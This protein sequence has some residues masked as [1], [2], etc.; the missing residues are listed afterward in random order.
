MNIQVIGMGGYGIANTI[1]FSAGGNVVR[2]VDFDS[3]LINSLNNKEMKIDDLELDRIYREREVIFCDKLEASDVYIITAPSLDYDEKVNFVLVCIERIKALLKK[4]DTIIL[5]TSLPPGT[6]MNVVKPILEQTGLVA[7]VDFYLANVPRKVEPYYSDLTLSHKIIGG[8]GTTSTKK[9]KEIYQFINKG[10]IDETDAKTAEVVKSMESTYRDISIAIANELLLVCEE[11][12]VDPWLAI[13]LANQNQTVN[14]MSPGTGVGGNCIPTNPTFLIE[15]V[16]ANTSSLLRNAR[17]RNNSMPIKVTRDIRSIVKEFNLNSISLLGATYKANSDEQGPSPTEEIIKFLIDDE[18]EYSVY[19]PYLKG[20][21]PRLKYEL[22]EAI[23]ESSL[24]VFLV[25]HKDFID[26]NPE[27]I[28]QRT[29]S[30]MIFD[31][32]G[33]LNVGQWQNAGFKVFRLGCVQSEI[34]NRE[35]TTW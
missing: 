13:N 15:N 32:T 34:L 23:Q 21:F 10:R 4:G 35:A 18:I 20:D 26:L 7:D 29:E 2:G 8:V 28:I 5:E 30:R 6:T 14:I 11:L 9:V 27:S 25:G 31:C 1:L 3:A 24:I 22:T 16:S 12:G 33:K 17:A 19:D